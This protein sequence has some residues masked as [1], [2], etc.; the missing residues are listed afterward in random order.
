MNEFSEGRTNNQLTRPRVGIAAW[1]ESSQESAR[2]LFFFAVLP[3]SFTSSSPASSRAPD[4][5]CSL[6]RAS[7]AFHRS[8]FSL[9]PAV[10]P[11]TTV[12]A[13]RRRP[14][15]NRQPKREGTRNENEIP[16][17]RA[18]PPRLATSAAF[19]TRLALGRDVRSPAPANPGWL[20]SRNRLRPT[21]SCTS[22]PRQKLLGGLRSD[23][24]FSPGCIMQGG[25][26]AEYTVPETP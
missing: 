6:V 10:H 16:E 4:V 17:P 13:A 22:S 3:R 8:P 25:R 1:T 14:N 23:R 12:G 24:R 9:L 18:A 7:R 20:P 15:R 21:S 2:V 5:I 19:R 26:R 11:P